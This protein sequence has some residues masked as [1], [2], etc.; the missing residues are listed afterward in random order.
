MTKRTFWLWIANNPLYSNAHI[1]FKHVTCRI[2]IFLP[3]CTQCATQL[4]YRYYLLMPYGLINQHTK[5]TA[6]MWQRTASMSIGPFSRQDA[7]PSLHST[8]QPRTVDCAQCPWSGLPPSFSI[9]RCALRRLKVAI[10]SSWTYTAPITA[11]EN[12]CVCVCTNPHRPTDRVYFPHCNRF[13]KSNI[14]ASSVVR[15]VWGKSRGRYV[16]KEEWGIFQLTFHTRLL[17]RW[18]A[19]LVHLR[20]F[21]KQWKQGRERIDAMRFSDAKLLRDIGGSLFQ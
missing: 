14:D 7:C 10:L 12:M 9:K 6:S 16:K 2:H 5:R 15:T 17:S 21:P 4:L 20:Y 19:T 13:A 11:S 3:N 8:N 18:T 1:L